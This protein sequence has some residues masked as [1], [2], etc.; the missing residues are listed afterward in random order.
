MPDTSYTHSTLHQEFQL[1][2]HHALLEQ[3]EVIAA[4]KRKLLRERDVW[5]PALLSAFRHL[6]LDRFRVALCSRARDDLAWLA[7]ESAAGRVP[8]S[9]ADISEDSF[10]RLVFATIDEARWEEAKDEFERL[11][12]CI[13]LVHTHGEGGQQPA[14]TGQQMFSLLTGLVFALTFHPSFFEESRRE[15]MIALMADQV[16]QDV[17]G[18]WPG[19]DVRRHG[20]PPQQQSRIARIEKVSF[21]DYFRYMTGKNPRDLWEFSVEGVSYRVVNQWRGGA[22]LKGPGDE[23][24]AENNEVLAIKGTEPALSAMVGEPGGRNHR[25]DVYFRAWISVKARV[26]VDGEPLSA[27]FM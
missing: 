17:L 13:R 11:K 16:A 18:P 7:R 27:G 21:A 20:A 14:L 23:V 2:V 5:A 22:Q 6:A 4:D 8:Q 3:P 26:D 19:E 10:A 24:L 15:N 1:I 25:V 9:L 12:A